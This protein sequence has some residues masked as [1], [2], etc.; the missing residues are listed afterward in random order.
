MCQT[1]P[2]H[3]ATPVCQAKQ[4]KKAIYIL[5]YT[6]NLLALKND[7][8]QTNISYFTLYFVFYFLFE[9]LF[10]TVP[11]ILLHLHTYKHHL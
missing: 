7:T 2:L 5:K 3:M 6:N 11:F 4:T 8:V 10:C 1:V 9:Y